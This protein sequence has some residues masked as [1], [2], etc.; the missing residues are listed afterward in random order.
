[1]NIVGLYV[2]HKE[3]GR[4]VVLFIKRSTQELSII[5]IPLSYIECN[6]ELLGSS[7]RLLS[8]LFPFF[9]LKVIIDLE[10]R[11]VLQDSSL[12]SWLM[13]FLDQPTVSTIDL[14]Q[15]FSSFDLSLSFLCGSGECIPLS[16]FFSPP[17]TMVHSDFTLLLGQ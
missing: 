13:N 1:M 11:D 8:L 9:V 10:F 2:L 15:T 17:L 16:T 14:E 4:A 5:I 6:Q 3:E 12:A 7:I